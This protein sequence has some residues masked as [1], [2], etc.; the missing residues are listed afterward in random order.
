MYLCP[1]IVVMCISQ[2]SRDCSQDGG[3][4]C[5]TVAYNSK[6]HWLNTG[7]TNND[8]NA[9]AVAQALSRLGHD[10]QHVSWGSLEYLLWMPV[11]FCTCCLANKERDAGAGWRCSAAWPKIGGGTEGSPEVQVLMMNKPLCSGSLAKCLD[12]CGWTHWP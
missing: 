12:Q 6:I 10:S 1:D 2:T 4:L 3:Y 9:N 8:N 11:H 5:T 7:S